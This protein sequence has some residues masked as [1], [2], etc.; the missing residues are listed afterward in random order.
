MQD[1]SQSL[2]MRLYRALNQVM[3]PFRAIFTAHG[4]TEAQ[5]RVLRV[6]WERDAIGFGELAA[7][8][9]LPAPSLV[10]I[11]DRMA[12]RGWV[13]RER[14]AADR[15]QVIV[16][17]TADGRALEREVMPAVEAAYR[18]LRASI[19]DETW[20]ALSRGLDALVVTAPATLESATNEPI[21]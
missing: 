14:S 3:P 6:L 20:R 13:T 18:E 2:P 11:V 5:W 1:F 8:T 9:L 12:A 17:V 7:L 21:T 16:G 15:R 19:D 10:G 4:L